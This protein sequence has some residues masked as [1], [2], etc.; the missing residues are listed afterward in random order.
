MS[1]SSVS[2]STSGSTASS[3]YQLNSLGTGSSMQITGL[4]SGLNTDQI[5]QEEMALYNQP[6][7]NLQ[8]QQSG[9]TAQN[10]ALSNIQSELQ[11]LASDAMALQDPSLFANTQNVT[12]SDPTRVTASTSS[13]AGVGGYQVSV[14]A[15]ASAAQKTFTYTPPTSSD[16]ITLDGNQQITI[17]A[18][19]S[20]TDFVNSVNSNS[21]L[22]IYAAAT[23]A[24]T[25]V[26]SY[27]Q[28]GSTGSSYISIADTGG[29][30]N[31]TGAGMP[32][33]DASY[34]INNG[35]AQ[36]S[37]SNTITGAI[38]GVTLNL[39]GV[40]TTSGP[41][42]VNV[43]PPAPS[44]S[45]IQSAVNTFVSQYNKVISDLQTQLSTAPSSSDPT[46]GTLYQDPELQGLL[47]SM[48]SAMYTSQNGSSSSS[49]QSL[50]NIGVSTGATTGS[51]AVSQSALNGTL[52]F[53]TATL[54]SALQSDP[55]GVQQ[56]MVAF[57][58]SFSTL[59]GSAADPGGTIDARMQGDNSQISD[60]GN[61]I[62]AMQAAL[63]DK[64]NQLVQ[65]FAQLESALSS[66]QSTASWLTSQIAALPGA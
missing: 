34:S 66:N 48:R 30:L 24:N 15:L 63:S 54:T 25:V 18:G 1:T 21:K 31:P 5:I 3:G 41:I 6:V 23:D 17:P 43:S 26:F 10:K 57:G 39:Q 56:M 42:T 58:A 65:Q 45:N 33:Q 51:G 55:L 11:T 35:T 4:A 59:V 28:T 50:L 22:S 8:N 37:S 29:A 62:T 12:S 52:Q 64:Q 49:I 20:I 27:R 61:Q 19:Q 13:G 32:G 53:N 40:T 7:T 16:T 60:L 2:S 46:V 14:T 9:L 36:T 47:T 38:A 44:S